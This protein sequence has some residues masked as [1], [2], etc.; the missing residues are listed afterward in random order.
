MLL[1]YCSPN[2]IRVFFSFHTFSSMLIVQL[3][4]HC[5]STRV[6][7]T[8]PIPSNLFN[9]LFPAFK[10]LSYPTIS[11]VGPNAAVIHYGPD[12]KTCS[13]LDPDN[14]YLFDSGAQ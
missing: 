1:L 5:S 12:P 8:V 2:S 3:F 6:P 4:V 14:I 7:L 13:E 9:V 11:S 10:G